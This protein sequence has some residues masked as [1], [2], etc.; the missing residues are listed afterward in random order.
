MAKGLLPFKYEIE[1]GHS[2]MTQYAGLGSYLDLS[3]AVRLRQSIEKHVNARDQEQGYTDN[4][5]IFSLILLNLTGGESMDDLLML[6]ADPGLMNLLQHTQWSGKTRSERRKLAKRWCKKKDDGVFP[7]PSSGFRYINSYHDESWDKDL[8][9]GKAF[10][11]PT[12]AAL[13]GLYNV[14][15]KMADFYQRVSPQENAT[16]DFDATIAET[17]KKNALYSYKGSKSYQ[18]L[19]AYWAETGLVVNSEFRSGNVPAGYDLKRFLI[20][21]IQHLP[22]G[23]KTLSIRSDTA[24]YQWDLI[25]YC[26]EEKSERFGVIEFGIGVDVTPAFKQAVDEVPEKD[27]HTYIKTVKG[28]QFETNQQWAEVVFVP[29]AICNKKTGPEYR[30]IATREKIPEQLELIEPKSEKE[31]QLSFNFPTM[32]MNNAGK[33]CRYKIFGIVTNR[34]IPGNELIK[35]F[36]QRCGESELVHARMKDDF[37]GGRFPTDKFGANAAWWAIM[38]LA[39]NLSVLMQRLVLGGKWAKKRMKAI[40]FALINIAASVRKRSRTL[41]VRLNGNSPGYKLLLRARERIIELITIV[42][43]FG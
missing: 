2:F 25:K 21:T 29:N 43:G 36:R 13:K 22:A 11:P 10:I 18:P 24:G 15:G 9:H 30:F 23:I 27:W 34:T 26:A 33:C 4:E 12:T 42:T 3:H 5:V 38:I 19:N 32:L 8:T 35:W 41:F 31:R 16:V 37:A 6:R 7:S 28:E 20:R 17:N 1:T 14:N 40:R 39:L